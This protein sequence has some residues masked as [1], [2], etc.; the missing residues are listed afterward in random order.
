VSRGENS[1]RNSTHFAP[2]EISK[3]V[4]PEAFLPGSASD[5]AKP[6]PTGS[7]TSV[8]MIGIVRVSRASASA[9]ALV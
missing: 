5:A 4:K 2:N 6:L 3:F 9:L 1:L 7:V 8:N